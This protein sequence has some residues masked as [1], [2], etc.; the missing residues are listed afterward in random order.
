MIRSIEQARGEA[1]GAA[2]QAAVQADP[3]ALGSGLAKDLRVSLMMTR[4]LGPVFDIASNP[5]DI[6]NVLK[7]SSWSSCSPTWTRPGPR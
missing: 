4:G 7:S 6:A 5:L 1:D 2:I 3:S